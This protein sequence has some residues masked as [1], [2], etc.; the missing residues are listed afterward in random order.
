[1]RIFFASLGLVLA[2]LF[3]TAAALVLLDPGSAVHADLARSRESILATVPDPEVRASLRRDSEGFARRL[4][5][6][7][8]R[9]VGLRRFDARPALEVSALRL[10]L[11]LAVLP[12][13]GAAVLLG[14][15]AGLLRRRTLID[16]MGYHS[17]T[18][19]YLGKAAFAISLGA[20]AFTA[21]SPIGPPVWTL[22]AF[23][24]TATAGAGLY[25][26]NLPPKL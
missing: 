22:Y 2:A 3:G 14:A 20:Y 16:R 5:P 10:A 6:H 21:V 7:L 11:A 18:W 26:G 12:V 1:M 8:S 15:V 19:S 9:R 4:H 25:F 17:L 24:A 23:T 13:S